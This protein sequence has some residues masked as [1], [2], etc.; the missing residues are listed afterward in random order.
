[1]SQIYELVRCGKRSTGRNEPDFYFK[2]IF[3][4][5]YV[6]TMSTWRPE[7]GTRSPGAGVID[8]CKLLHGC[9]EQILGPLQG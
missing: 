3:C 1:M 9:W 4:M 7:G 8:H 2:I 6:H 5:Y